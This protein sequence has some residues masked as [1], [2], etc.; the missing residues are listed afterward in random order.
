MKEG[1]GKSI[2]RGLG[3]RHSGSVMYLLH[4]VVKG[5][6]S[7]WLQILQYLYVHISTISF[8]VQL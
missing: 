6:V 7:S 4:D 8:D 5:K 1:S 2:S 3:E